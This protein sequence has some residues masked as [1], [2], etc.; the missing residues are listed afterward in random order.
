MNAV[1]A[2]EHRF[3]RTPDGAVWTQTMFPYA[4][5]TRYLEVFDGVRVT[6]R[7]R[8]VTTIP[9][10]WI[11]AD[12]VGIR[13]AAVPHYI[14][15]WEYLLRARA[16]RRRVQRSFGPEDAVI[17]RVG[18]RIATDLEPAL[19]R[20]G[21]P[22]GVEV[23]CDPYDVFA[24]G[25]VRHPL[26]PF[27]RWWSPRQLR[28]QCQ[29]AVAAAYVTERALQR[30]YPPATRAFATSFSDVELPDGAFVTAPRGAPREARARTIVTVG[31]LA[32]LY[33]AP[34][35]LIDAVGM[36]VR[37]GLDLR[38]VLI[39]D[40][41][42]RPDLERRARG[43]GLTERVRFMGQLPA[44]EAV[45]DALDSADL[46]VLPSHQEGLPRAMVEAMARALPCIGSTVGGFPELLPPEDMVPPGNAVA[47]AA[48]ISEVLREPDRLERMSARNL[49][50]ARRYR[51][52]VV[53]ERRLVFY[54][55]LRQVTEAW[56][57]RA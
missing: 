39:G 29:Q 49:D 11:R 44:G 33:K 50:T 30:R 4:F 2:L 6:A 23:V 46:F 52:T 10:G 48:R 51:D 38:L 16:V 24:P 3:V 37:G 55:Q 21:H 9:E 12:G 18:S 53:R 54:T 25:A 27:F 31:T 19:R 40:G 15:P 41:K 36:M 35:V 45:R 34:D 47:L 13:F 32:Q 26:R 1:V 20:V 8:E 17:L 28:R 56:C 43:L 42:Y 22:F 7:V 57:A 5:W 14:G